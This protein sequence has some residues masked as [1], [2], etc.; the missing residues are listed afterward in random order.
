MNY[1]ISGQESS[2]SSARC[3]YDN[4]AERTYQ[5]FI[6][7]SMHNEIYERPAGA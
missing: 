2:Y 1:K 3:S 4:L 5:K 6:K 7:D